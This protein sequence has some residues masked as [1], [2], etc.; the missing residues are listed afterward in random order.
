MFFCDDVERIIA[1]A[2]GEKKKWFFEPC[3]KMFR[4]FNFLCFVFAFE[5]AHSHT[6]RRNTTPRH[7]CAE[8]N[9]QR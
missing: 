1:R 5:R 6:T 2:L 4:V 7:E 9:H 3:K 8:K